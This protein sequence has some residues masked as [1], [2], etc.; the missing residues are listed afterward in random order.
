MIG[1]LGGGGSDERLRRIEAVT[2]ATLSKLDVE[3]LFDEMLDRT[4]DLLGV[5]TA[6][7]L[8]LDVHSRQL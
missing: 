3:D 6:A 4:R 5:D 8:L 1:T 2:D 7:V